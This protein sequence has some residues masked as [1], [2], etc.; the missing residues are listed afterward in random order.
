MTLSSPS[1]AAPLGQVDP[2]EFLATTWQRRPRLIRAAQAPAALAAALPIKDVLALARD[3]DVESRLVEAPSPDGRHGWRLRPGPFARLPSRQRPGWT[4]LVQG[5]DLHLPAGRALLDRFR[6]IP[7]ARIDDL[8]ISVARD[9]G[10]VGPHVDSY[11]VFRLQAP[12]RRRWRVAP[13]TRWRFEADVPLRVIADFEATETWVLEPGDLLYVPPGWAHEGTALGECMTC[14]IGFRAPS[15][16]EIRRAFFGMLADA[17][18]TLT[19]GPQG[20]RRYRDVGLRPV[21]AP[22]RIPAHL[23]A[24]LRDWIQ[25]FKADDAQVA[26]FIGQFLSEP[27]PQVWFEPA[28]D[29]PQQGGVQSGGGQSGGVQLDRRSRMLYDDDAIYL[30]GETFRPGARARRWL[31]KLADQRALDAA[32]TRAARRIAALD[33]TLADW[34]A[35]GWLHHAEQ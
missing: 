21:D 1:H 13:P 12:G 28:E 4:V 5:V 11:D 25:R 10:G 6:C 18:D 15:A 2:A 22:A 32:D 3:E 9:G 8:M 17:G 30:N 35:N 34:L 16:G 19:Q 24:T 33:E 26:R 29:S 31:C 23:Q 14:S 27:K 20:E 7:D